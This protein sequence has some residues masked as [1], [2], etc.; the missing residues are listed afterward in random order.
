MLRMVTSCL[1]VLV[2]LPV[3]ALLSI[4]GVAAA[5]VIWLTVVAAYCLFGGELD[6]TGQIKVC[7]ACRGWSA[8]HVKSRPSNLTANAQPMMAA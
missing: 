5:T 8:G 7:V 2:T 6:S 4:V 3:I 1:L